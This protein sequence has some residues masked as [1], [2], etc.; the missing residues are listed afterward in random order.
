[1]NSVDQINPL[2]IK[3]VDSLDARKHI[4]LFYD[5]SE[6]ARFIEFRFLKNGLANGEQCVYATEEDSGSIVLKMLRYG[7][8]LEYFERKKLR[9][10]QIH[11]GCGNHDE[12]MRS[13]KKDIGMIL[14]DLQP[15]FRIVSRIVADVSTITGMSVEL[16]LERETHNLFDNLG[17]SVMCPYDLS[18]IE[19]SRHNEWLAELRENH[20]E[21]IVA[22]KFGYGRI[23]SV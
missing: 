16:E 23:L 19:A 17:G 18:K 3:Y 6:Y 2:P 13:C 20:H 9:V 5:E 21:V 7:I 22:P 12:I 8:P 15:P 14:S 11:N 10:Y 4:A 1:M